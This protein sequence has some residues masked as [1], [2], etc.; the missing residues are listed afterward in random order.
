MAKSSATTWLLLAAAAIGVWFFFFRTQDSAAVL[1]DQ[2]ASGKQPT[3]PEFA[4]VDQVTD[5]ADAIAS[6][7]LHL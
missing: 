2:L 4:S 1:A 6:E 3:V 5:V 7:T